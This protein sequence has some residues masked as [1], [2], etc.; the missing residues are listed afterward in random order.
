MDTEEPAHPKR[1]LCATVPAPEYAA[2]EAAAARAGLTLSDYIR[3]KLRDEPL[4]APLA[5]DAESDA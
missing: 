4:P 3:H 1:Q 5:E 2:H